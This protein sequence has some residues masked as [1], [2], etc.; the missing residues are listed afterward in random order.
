ML[1]KCKT[2]LD[3]CFLMEQIQVAVLIMALGLNER[4]YP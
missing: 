3:E 1:L 2:Y 4:V